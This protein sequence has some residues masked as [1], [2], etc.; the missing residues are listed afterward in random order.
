MKMHVR[1]LL[2]GHCKKL[3]VLRITLMFGIGL[4]INNALLL[5]EGPPVN[6]Y[7]SDQNHLFFQ[8]IFIEVEGK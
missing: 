8:D 5:D 1:L 2:L 7:V 3:L 4:W 6:Q